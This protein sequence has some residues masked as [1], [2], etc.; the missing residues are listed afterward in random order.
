MLQIQA[1]LQL[2]AVPGWS[3]G[4]IPPRAHCSK[5]NP[6]FLDLPW[7]SGKQVQVGSTKRIQ[8]LSGNNADKL[9]T[10]RE[11][12]PQSVEN[13]GSVEKKS[14]VKLHLHKR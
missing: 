11:I 12:Q 9:P 5:P 7:T 1:V 10:D 8:P 6:C 4:V 3:K 14:T 2:A 13:A